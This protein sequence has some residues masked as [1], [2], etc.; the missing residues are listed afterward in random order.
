MKNNLPVRQNEIPFP[1]GKYLVSKT[2]LKGIITYANDAFVEI[3]GFGRDELLGA[4]HNLVRHP[5]MPEQAFG[6]LWQTVQGGQPWRG[7]VKNRA[8]DGSFYWVE[9]FVVPLQKDG[10]TTGYMSVRSPPTPAAVASAEDLYRKLKEGKAKLSSTTGWLSGLSLRSRMLWA[11]VGVM[12]VLL[13]GAYV[14]VTGLRDSN[15]A[16]ERVYKQRMEPLSKVSRLSALVSDART[17]LMLALQHDPANPLSNLHDHAIDKHFDAIMAGRQEVDKLL[18]DL[19]SAELAPEDRRQLEKINEVRVRYRAE[20]GNPMQE[21]LKRGDFASAQAVLLKKVVPLLQEYANL[22]DELTR[23]MLS[24]SQRDYEA[25][26]ERYTLQFN[27]SLW[28]SLISLLGIAGGGVLLIRSVVNPIRRA[29]RHFERI[30][31]GNLTGDIDFSGR[32]ELGQM[33]S[34]LATMQVHL[35]VMLDEIN[36]N[37]SIIQARSMQLQDEMALVVKQSQEQF[38]RVQSTAA[39]TEEFSQSVVDVADS[40]ERAAVAAMSSQQLV[41]DSN[42]SISSSMDATERVVSAVQESS[43]TIGALNDSIDRI[44]AITQTIKEIADQTNL[45]ALNAAIEAARAGEAGR[46][47]AVVADEVRKLAERTGSSTSDISGMVAEIQS[48]THLA[49]ESMSQA[50]REVEEGV[51][52]MRD[53]VSGLNRITVTSGDVSLQARHIAEAAKEQAVASE[54][55]AGNMEQITSLIESNTAAAHEAWAATDNLA[56]TAQSLKELVGYFRLV[57]A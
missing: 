45:L 31:E 7:I 56:R 34:G 28:G 54:Q 6:D 4:N 12:L 42:T 37:S 51:G 17:Q 16:L 44:G 46:G 11:V 3:S 52:M 26:K 40:A 5:D 1:Q 32:D 2:D 47:F 43:A 13:G 20:G 15:Q 9:A 10:K 14:G 36:A 41:S 22:C 49:V 21:A 55:V 53:S 27:L 24:S 48:A 39:A 25:S 23:Q 30:A 29:V 57:Q 19:K 33:M 18:S 38:D 8:K 50:V 35:K